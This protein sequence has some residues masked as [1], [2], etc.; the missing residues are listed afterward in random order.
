MSID[1][2]TEDFPRLRLDRM[3][4]FCHLLAMLSSRIPWQQI[5]ASVP[6]HFSG[7]VRADKKLAGI[8]LFG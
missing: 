2:A 1:S 3:F 5:E 6:H 4:N 8:D 7:K